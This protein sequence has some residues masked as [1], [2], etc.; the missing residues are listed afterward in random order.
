MAGAGATDPGGGIGFELVKGCGDGVLVGFHQPLIAGKL[1]DDGDGLGSGEGEVV[2]IAA[3]APGGAIGGDAVGTP[4]LPEKFP[5]EGMEALANGLEVFGLDVAGEAEKLSAA[6]E[7][8][9]DDPLAFSV[10]IAMGQVPGRIAFAVG[11]GADRQHSDR[12]GVVPLGHHLFGNR[13]AVGGRWLGTFGT[14]EL[15]DG[16]GLALIHPVLDAVLLVF[17][18]AHGA[19]HQNVGTFLETGRVFGEPI[20]P[21]DDAV[22]FG[23]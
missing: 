4:A 19:F 11:H 22:P 15:E 6:A 18:A 13:L 3:V 7:P 5:G 8:A 10:V 16:I 14:V 9:A 1:G 2:E 17:A 21:Y 20:A 23:V 12:R